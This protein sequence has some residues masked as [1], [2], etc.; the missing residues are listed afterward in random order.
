[1]I[2]PIFSIIVPSS[3]ITINTGLLSY[4]TVLF[5]GK[6]YI[7]FSL[8]LLSF[9]SHA[10]EVGIG[11]WRVHL[12]YSDAIAVADAGDRVYCAGR[13]GLFY[14]EKKGDQ[15]RRLS[16]VD[17]LSEVEISTIRY[18]SEAGI[19][20]V[21]YSNANI[22]LLQGS[23]ITN[24]SDIRRKNIPGKKSIN[25]ITMSG[26]D[27]YLSC[28]FGIVVIDL[29]RKEVKDTYYP[30]AAAI[31]ILDLASD[32]T[33]FYAATP[34]GIY[35]ASVSDPG[36]ANYTA[37]NRINN[38]PNNHSGARFNTICCYRN[39]LFANLSNAPAMWDKDSIFEYDGNTWSYH[40]DTISQPGITTSWIVNKIETYSGQLV[41]T[42]R[43][44]V[45]YYDSTGTRTYIVAG[46]DTPEAHP[47]QG[48]L[49][50]ENTRWV[51]DN[52]LGLV[53]NW[54][55]WDTKIYTPGGP[56][57]KSVVNMQV[58]GSSL[59]VATGGVDETWKNN[60]QREGLLSFSDNTWV[61]YNGRNVPALDTMID[62]LAVAIDPSDSKHIYAGSWGKGLIEMYNGKAV[63]V[64][65]DKNSPLQS[66]P[67][68]IAIAGLTFDNNANLWV[69]NV[70]AKSP[71]SMRK[72]DGSWVSYT[73]VGLAKELVVSKIIIDSYN[74]KW[75]MMP[76]G[77]GLLV[78]DAQGTNVRQVGTAPGG[79]NLPSANV[80]AAALDLEG[81][82]WI[83]TDKGVAVIYNPGNVF[84]GSDYDAQLIYVQQDAHTQILLETE[85]ITSIAIDGANR[86]W[87]G[88]LSGGIFL[89]SADGTRQIQHFTKDNSPLISDVITSVAINQLTGEVFIGTDKGIVSYKGTATGGGE[90]Y[91]DVYVY[92]NPVRDTY[93]GL[94]GIKGLV[95]DAQV[96]ISDVSGNI[97]YETVADGGQATWNGKKFDGERVHTGVYMVY[98]SDG[99]GKKTYMTK[100]LIIH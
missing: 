74:Q 58:S 34:S 54:N 83:G 28:S 91:S 40:W 99:E 94:I 33:V 22:D 32:G 52:R 59:W 5:R 21:A 82:M 64:Y 65:N 17:G 100:L 14:V 35:T 77:G 18:N 51:A 3:H 44:S 11:Q 75:V 86:K 79:G 81:Q 68:G 10:Q 20:L 48:I 24:L 7:V 90:E 31:E 16:K 12:P 84:T 27:A 93:S 13:S 73:L 15:L 42:N 62:L 72:P 61:T 55:I 38:L 92:P 50:N 45:S 1:M 71:L 47:M 43:Y 70:S 69:A 39:K 9:S 46:Y 78:M 23:S 66:S 41:I 63:G 95:K 30:S 67:W 6:K 56:Q 96:K 49:D 36:I 60:Y 53:K 2:P 88:T 25:N 37:W 85:T 80:S 97:V 87:I 19:L 29:E 26:H 76:R 89:M 98:C 57:T 4:I 8:A